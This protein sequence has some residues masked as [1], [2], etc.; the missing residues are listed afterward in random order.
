VRVD[1]ARSVAGANRNHTLVQVSI[2]PD[3]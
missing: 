2:G 3:L 1:F